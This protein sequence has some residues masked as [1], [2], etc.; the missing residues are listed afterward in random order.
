[1][2]EGKIKAPIHPLSIQTTDSLSPR[3]IVSKQQDETQLATIKDARLSTEREKNNGLRRNSGGQ[4]V[5]D[6]REGAARDNAPT[7]SRILDSALDRV[8]GAATGFRKRAREN[9][10]LP[11]EMHS[12]VCPLEGQRFGGPARTRERNEA[13]GT[14]QAFDYRR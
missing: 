9:G 3:R 11:L 5:K 10:S 2:T 1:M 6:R 4:N 13:R 8:V 12:H 14:S 7:K